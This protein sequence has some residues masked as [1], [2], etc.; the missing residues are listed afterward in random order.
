M[1]VIGAGIDAAGQLGC[2]SDSIS[3]DDFKI[4]EK[5]R[6]LTFPT[7]DLVW[8]STGSTQTHFVYKDGTLCVSGNDNDNWIGSSHR[9]VLETP[10]AVDFKVKII[11]T[12]A[13]NEYSLYLTNKGKMFICSSQVKYKRVL[14]EAPEPITMIFG[15]IDYPGAIG[16]SGS[17]YVF[18]KER[19]SDKPI[20]Y[21]LDRPVVDLCLLRSNKIY[22]LTDDGVL[23]SGVGTHPINFDVEESLKHEKIVQ[24]SG[25]N[26]FSLALSAKGEVYSVGY[27]KY[28]QL[29]LGNQNDTNVFNKVTFFNGM[30]VKQLNAGTLHS[31][32]LTKSGELWGF[33]CNCYGQLMNGTHTDIEKSPIR[34]DTPGPVSFVSGYGNYT[35]ALIG[36]YTQSINLMIPKYQRHI[37]KEKDIPEKPDS[38]E[39]V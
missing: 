12:A 13:G 29:G 28:A 20:A 26:Q 30:Q 18:K 19:L 22:A 3:T 33:G 24:I 11:M 34:V 16:I 38:K 37:P 7:Q 6:E 39:M 27:N 14:I 17:F 9:K 8:V 2:P 35:V 23:Y 25:F 4:V 1:K 36:D 5:L 31:F 21:K 32:V 15:G 10:T